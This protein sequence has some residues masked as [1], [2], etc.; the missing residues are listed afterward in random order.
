MTIVPEHNKRLFEICEPI[1]LGVCEAHRLAQ[2]GIALNCE[3]V[4]DDFLDR[5]ADCENGALRVIGESLWKQRVEPALRCFVDSMVENGAASIAQEWRK[6]R[7]AS[8]EPHKITAGDSAFF[9]SYLIPSLE[10]AEK[11]KLNPAMRGRGL[12]R[13][14]EA[15][16]DISDELS[17]ELEVYYACLRLGF[18][19]SYAKREG[20]LAMLTSRL[21]KFVPLISAR[22]ANNKVTEQAY[23][24]TL[25]DTLTVAVKPSVWGLALLTI[26]FVLFFF[27]FVGWKYHRATG[28]LVGAVNS[29]TNP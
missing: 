11:L 29:I 6:A 4:R 27:A 9:T 15:E 13:K 2:A 3:R 12:G 10:A 28:D 20:D 26:M 5:L 23:K 14:A 8:E 22:T 19:G 16:P 7:L 18:I 24:S 25:T 17:Q 1:F 21:G